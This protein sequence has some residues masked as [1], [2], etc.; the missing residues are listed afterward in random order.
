MEEY[1]VIGRTNG[2]TRQG[3]PYATLKVAK[4]KEESFAISVWDLSPT[5]GPM[6]GQLVSFFSIKDFQGKMS[7]GAT[8]L[9]LGSMPDAMHPLYH[10]VHSISKS[11][12]LIQVDTQVGCEVQFASQVAYDALEEGVDRLNTEVVVIM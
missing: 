2:T 7:C 10:L 4:S 5:A 6:L 9:R 11:F 8:D 3:S 1:L 12:I